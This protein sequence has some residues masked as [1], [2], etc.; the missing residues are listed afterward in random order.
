MAC[1][2]EIWPSSDGRL[3]S[4][5]VVVE[6]DP[7]PAGISSCLLQLRLVCVS[8]NK[9]RRTPVSEW[10]S[11]AIGRILFSPQTEKKI[12]CDI[13]QNIFVFVFI[14]ATRGHCCRERSRNQSHP[15]HSAA[16][17]EVVEMEMSCLMEMSVCGSDQLRHTPTWQGRVRVSASKENVCFPPKKCFILLPT[18]RDVAQREH[19]I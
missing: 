4:K 12:M 19:F 15:S 7:P 13:F 11:G 6:T 10:K 18:F 8:A 14:G 16:S 5:W 2:E 3:R 1:K 9:K 17:D